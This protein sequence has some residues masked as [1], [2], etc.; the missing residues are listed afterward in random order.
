MRTII[1]INDNWKF[2]KDLE[3]NNWEY[4]NIPH[5][6]NSIDGAEGNEY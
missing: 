4:I 3:Q 1:N 6:W 5:T 2:T